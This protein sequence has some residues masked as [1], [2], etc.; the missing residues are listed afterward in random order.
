MAPNRTVIPA[1]EKA[2]G[3]PFLSAVRAGLKEHG[4]IDAWCR[5][6]GMRMNRKSVL[7]EIDRLGYYIYQAPNQLRKKTEGGQS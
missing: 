4:S 1:I 3:K 5:A 2:T 7:R 6:M